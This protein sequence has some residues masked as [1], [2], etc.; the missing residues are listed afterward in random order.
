MNFQT[1][2]QHNQRPH[3]FGHILYTKNGEWNTGYP[4]KHH[5]VIWMMNPS[6]WRLWNI[7]C[8]QRKQQS[9]PHWHPPQYGQSRSHSKNRTSPMFAFVNLHSF[10]WMY[11]VQIEGKL[12]NPSQEN[13]FVRFQDST[14][15]YLDAANRLAVQNP[16]NRS[17]AIVENSIQEPPSEKRELG[18]HE[19]FL[20]QRSPNGTTTHRLGS[21]T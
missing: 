16:P 13:D 2:C 17:R 10:V 1:R 6:K 14:C 4:D 9:S 19:V 12:T 3:P 15:V 18:S 20:I 21:T 7:Q 8:C 11:R 5:Q